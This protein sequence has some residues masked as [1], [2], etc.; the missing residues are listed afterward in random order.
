L[1]FKAHPE[2]AP[3]QPQRS[4]DQVEEHPAP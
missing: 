3:E 4:G 2:D 1:W